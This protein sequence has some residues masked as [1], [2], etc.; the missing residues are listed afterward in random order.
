[1]ACAAELSVSVRCLASRWV[2]SSRTVASLGWKARGG[3]AALGGVRTPFAAGHLVSPGRTIEIER[4]GFDCTCAGA[5]PCANRAELARPSVDI[6]KTSCSRCLER[7]PD[8]DCR[9]ALAR[10]FGA[11]RV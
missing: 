5:R 9:L 11:M 1:M 4:T 8:H 2:V 3:D 6:G 7:R 10:G